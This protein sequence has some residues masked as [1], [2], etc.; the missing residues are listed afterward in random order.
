MSIALKVGFLY[1]LPSRQVSNIIHVYI[2]YVNIKSDSASLYFLISL[3]RPNNLE[4]IVE[5]GIST[6]FFTYLCYNIF[7]GL[8]VSLYVA[9]ISNSSTIFPVHYSNPYNEPFLI[10][11]LII[12]IFFIVNYP[13]LLAQGSL[14]NPTIH[15]RGRDHREFLWSYLKLYPNV[16]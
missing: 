14:H 11:C 3:L 7:F 16:C 15:L 6:I 1:L 4:S 9:F 13:V 10:E 8:P 2:S 5:I 12:S